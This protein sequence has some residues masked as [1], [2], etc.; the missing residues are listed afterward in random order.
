MQFFQSF[1]LKGN[2]FWTL[3]TKCDFYSFEYPLWS[4]ATPFQMV[5]PIALVEPIAIGQATFRI[6]TT[7]QVGGKLEGASRQLKFSILGVN[8]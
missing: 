6:T 3:A 2:F 8:R 4:V 5:A 7:K 1:S